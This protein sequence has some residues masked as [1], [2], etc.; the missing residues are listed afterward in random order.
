MEL[1]LKKGNK[2]ILPGVRRKLD[3][4]EAPGGMNIVKKTPKKKKRDIILPRILHK[5]N[6]IRKVK[7][8]RKEVNHTM[9]GGIE[10]D[11]D[12]G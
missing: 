11:T 3:T 6:L 7:D 8:N 2:V 1:A 4:E 12:E 9:V 10:M 5:I